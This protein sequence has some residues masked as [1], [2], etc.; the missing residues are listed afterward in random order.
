M[1]VILITLCSNRAIKEKENKLNKNE[2]VFITLP[3][4]KQEELAYSLA[5]KNLI[6]K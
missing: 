4:P 2:L 3:T 6:L 5:K 1:F